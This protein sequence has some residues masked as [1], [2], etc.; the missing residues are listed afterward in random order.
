MGIQVVYVACP[1]KT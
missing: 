1:L